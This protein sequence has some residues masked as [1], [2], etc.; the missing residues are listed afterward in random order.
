[1]TNPL[2]A[3][4]A[5]WP[6]L[7]VTALL[8]TLAVRQR[9]LAA[10]GV[11][12]AFLN[13]P[14]RAPLYAPL[15]VGL[16][17]LVT[18]LPW[19]VRDRG[20]LRYSAGALCIAGVI[21]LANMIAIVR[22]HDITDFGNTL[23]RFVQGYALVAVLWA[24]W[25]RDGI[26]PTQRWL[27]GVTI[28][29][30]LLGLWQL[31]LGAWV[32]HT[33]YPFYWR[34]AFL[35]VEDAN[36]AGLYL[37]FLC[38]V[39]LF[40]ITHSP[41]AYGAWMALTLVVI[42]AALTLSRTTYLIG[43]ALCVA[44]LFWRWQ[45]RRRQAATTRRRYRRSLKPLVAC[46]VFLVMLCGAVAWVRMPDADLVDSVMQLNRARLA[47]EIDTM[48]YRTDTWSAAA[49]ALSPADWLVGQG[50]IDIRLWNSSIG[51][52]DATLH[53]LPLTLVAK[54]GLV[55]ACAYVCFL[56]SVMLV[57]LRRRDTW[58]YLGA[59]TALMYGSFTMLISDEV[60]LFILFLLMSA[61]AARREDA[62]PAP[63]LVPIRARA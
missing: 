42:C 61:V 58:G 18:L 9:R 14:N 55:A 34:F 12:F 26:L 31:S 1:M 45:Q 36:Y 25:R 39:A 51:G 54:Y 20:F 17:G 32:F 4:P 57:C 43:A 48:A 30:C 2:D 19:A 24:A 63:P 44:Q 23:G 11:L 38:A 41:R 56:G 13:L 53:N 59:G 10:A 29:S 60:G 52:P 46:A 6:V 5:L 37:C 28:V 62:A 27:Y 40:G 21:V 15:I 7:F 50:D 35:A 8:M 49:A 22:G 47:G 33:D 16:V 3:F